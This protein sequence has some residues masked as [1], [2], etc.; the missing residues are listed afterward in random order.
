MKRVKAILANVLQIDENSITDETS[1]E[2][3]ETWDSFNA[4]LLISEFEKAF[5][6]SFSLDEVVSVRCVGGIKKILKKHGIK[7]EDE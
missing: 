4:L 2:N 1:P 7:I 3:V 6:L 5:N